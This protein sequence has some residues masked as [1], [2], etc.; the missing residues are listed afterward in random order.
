MTDAIKDNSKLLSGYVQFNI[1]L[2]LH[3]YD[4]IPA[5]YKTD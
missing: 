4:L 3:L 5:V 2:S 1:E